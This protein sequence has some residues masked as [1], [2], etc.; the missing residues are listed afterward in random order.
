[1]RSTLVTAFLLPAVFAIKG[2]PL[3]NAPQ[4]YTAGHGA[5]K[6]RGARIMNSVSFKSASYEYTG[7]GASESSVD[8]EEDGTLIYSPAY[9]HGEVGYITS[10]DDGK[11]WTPVIPATNQSRAQPVFNIHD[12]RYFFWSSQSPGLQ[13]S[14]SDDKGKSWTLVSKHLQPD[15]FDWAKIISGKPVSSQLKNGTSKILYMSA[16]SLISVAAAPGFGPIEQRILKSTDKGETWIKTKGQPTLNALRSGGACEKHTKDG[17]NNEYIIWSDG[18]VRLN[19]TIMFGVRRCTSLSIA[20]SD[21]EGDTW[22]W[23][24]VPGSELVPYTAGL[25]T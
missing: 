9:T 20:I 19:G 25:D 16:P 4:V 3:N 12:G 8:I 2:G 7:F 13:L 22:R 24:D 14:Y 18:L 11:T 6:P 10:K 5:S 23:S 15:I 21:D 17:K 1:M